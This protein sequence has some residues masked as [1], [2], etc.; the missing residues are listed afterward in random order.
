MDAHEN[1]VRRPVR[2]LRALFQRDEDIGA[3][4]H[5]YLV[6]TIKE[7]PPCPQAHIQGKILFIAITAHSPF[8]ICSMSWI[9]HHGFYRAHVRDKF[10]S[11][12]RLDD[13][14]EIQAREK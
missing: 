5:Y 3:P 2:D 10:G 6:A 9:E 8:V 4:R 13:F 7:N 14:C 1:T 11:Q 12:G